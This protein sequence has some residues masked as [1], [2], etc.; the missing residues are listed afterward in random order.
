MGVS[1]DMTLLGRDLIR[2]AL[3]PGWEAAGRTFRY[4]APGI[5]PMLI[6]GTHGWIHLSIGR[7]DRWFRWGIL[8]LGVTASLFVLALRWG[9]VGIAGAWT[10]SFW[11]LMIP[12]LWY[13]GKPIGFGAGSVVGAIWRYMLASLLAGL[14]TAQILRGFPSFWAMSGVIGAA[15]RLVGVSLL[16]SVL[17][18]GGVVLLH[19]GLSPLRRVAALL[20]DMVPRSKRTPLIVVTTCDNGR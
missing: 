10:M 3:G 9:P 13:A 19:G 4:F 14:A 15:S 6:Y 1:G 12:A 8:E 17:Y 2:L 11:I 16:F 5:G 20:R 18:L 7:A